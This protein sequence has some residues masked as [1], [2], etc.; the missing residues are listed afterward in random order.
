MLTSLLVLDMVLELDLRLPSQ[1]REIE[2][3]LCL[4]FF[5]TGGLGGRG[6]LTRLASGENW[7]REVRAATS[8]TEATPRLEVLA[9]VST[10]ITEIWDPVVD[11]REQ[12]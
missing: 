12:T 6:V 11:G 8:I 1:S 2:R 5:D 4:C 3:L 9:E 10:Y 7:P